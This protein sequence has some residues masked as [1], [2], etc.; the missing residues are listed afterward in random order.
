MRV[1]KIHYFG[2]F[3]VG[4]HWQKLGMEAEL[5]AG[6]DVRQCW[7]ALKKQVEEFHY[8]SKAAAE[9]QMG[10]TEKWSTGLPELSREEIEAVSLPKKSQEETIIDGINSCTELKVL[11][12]YKLIAQKNESIKTAYDLK[13]L[14]LQK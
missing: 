11:E 3:P 4:L 6:D 14:E 8:E 2:T 1:T 9:K 12:S 7:Y 13:L 5:E 10:V